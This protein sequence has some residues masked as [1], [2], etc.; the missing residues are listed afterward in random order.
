MTPEQVKA[1]AALLQR[2]RG[3]FRT[4][5][6]L[7]GEFRPRTADDGY[8]IQDAFAHAWDSAVAGWKIAC[9]AV[10]QQTFLQVSE[11]FCGRVFASALLRS[12]AE[13]PAAA[14]HM[15]GLESE[16]AFRMGSDLPPRSTPYRRE[17]VVA[18]VASLHPAVEVV[19]SR[20]A[21]WLSVGA[22][23]LIAD[24]AANGALVCGEGEANWTRFD[25]RTHPVRLDVDGRTV[26][27][28]TG[29]LALGHPVDAL[30]WLANNLS[31]RGITLA[32]GQFV[33]TGTCTGIHFAAAGADARAD[34]GPLGA[35]RLAF[36]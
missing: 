19:D 35:V 11:P 9:T 32:T 26:G 14:F 15:R 13:L 27:E 31:R 24:N 12:P 20:F 2:V 6:E 10:N 28:G 16:F 29:G 23:S 34:F 17:E 1:A 25:L 8:A 4:I 30:V 5:A 33:T 7:P 22:P 21:D 3:D 36:A 18:A